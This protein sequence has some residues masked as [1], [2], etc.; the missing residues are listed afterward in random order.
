MKSNQSINHSKCKQ[1]DWAAIQPEA[2]PR[3]KDKAACNSIGRSFI[4]TMDI[5]LSQ[6]VF[7]KNKK[8]LHSISQR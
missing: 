7:N 1:F 3:R 4:H 6:I 5:P 2:W 8:I